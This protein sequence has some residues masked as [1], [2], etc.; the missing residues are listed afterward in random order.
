MIFSALLALV[1]LLAAE[2]TSIEVERADGRVF[3][4]ADMTIAAPRADVFAAL[5][6]YDH[7]HELSSRYLESRYLE[8]AED[9][10]PRIYTKVKGCV[11]FFCREIVLVDF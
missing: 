11:L 4:D 7:F 9:G 10:T 2:I 1:F 6:D 5:A 8:P 3:V